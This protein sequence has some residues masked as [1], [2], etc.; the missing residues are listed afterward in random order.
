M[1]KF[2]KRFPAVGLVLSLIFYLS[3]SIVQAET[4]SLSVYRGD[5]DGLYTPGEQVFV[6]ANPYDVG[7]ASRTVVEPNWVADTVR[8]FDYW[9]GDVELLQD[10]FAMRTSLLMPA[11]S[12]SIT[13]HYRDTARWA[14][15]R[16]ISYLPP[17]YRGVIFI[18]H[19]H[20]NC[21][22][23]CLIE[24]TEVHNFI[25]AALAELYGVVLVNANDLFG[26]SWDE[27]A[28]PNQNVDMERIAAV[29]K[30]LIDRGTLSATDPIY[31]LGISAGGVFASLFSQKAQ[32]QLGIPVDAMAL[33]ISPGNADIMPTTTVPTIFLLAENDDTNDGRLNELALLHH[34]ILLN[35]GIPSQL[36]IKAATPLYPNYFQAI[37]GLS[38]GD[39]SAIFQALKNGGLLDNRNYLLQHPDDSNWQQRLPVAYRSSA[40]LKNI[41]SL[42]LV[43]YAGHAFFSDYNRKVLDFFRQSEQ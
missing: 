22:A 20:G 3:I 4:F 16:V 28:S 34:N 9:S 37:E 41:Q 24:K 33:F 2:L 19:G 13:A 27:T 21:G 17:N 42:L 10:P 7:K 5:G 36:W 15:P 31:M 29:Y 43:A 8:V 6:W 32:D 40:Y 30:D 18:L 35:R 25:D 23:S 11:S 1:M 14:P 12:V 39:S 38:Q 26:D